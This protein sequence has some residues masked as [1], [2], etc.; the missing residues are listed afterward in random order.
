MLIT[1]N[2]GTSVS[3]NGVSI[4]YDMALIG[5][6]KFL[7][8]LEEAAKL[9]S[10][11]NNLTDES[12]QGLHD[13]KKAFE[14]RVNRT[15]ALW[16]ED[17][18]IAM[19][20]IFTLDDEVVDDFVSKIDSAMRCYMEGE[21]ELSPVRNRKRRREEGEDHSPNTLRQMLVLD[22]EAADRGEVRPSQRRRTRSAGRNVF[23]G[24]SREMVVEVEDSSSSDSE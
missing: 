12:T 17:L 7:S 4:E 24:T 10:S 15:I 22:R 18:D 14:S 2:E 9:H 13:A 23:E 8:K 21:A 1:V 6:A 16:R 3:H 19:Q 5:R 11:M 20:G